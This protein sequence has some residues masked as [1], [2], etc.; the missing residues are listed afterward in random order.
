MKQD[1]GSLSEL[2]GQRWQGQRLSLTIEDK[3]RQMFY[4]IGHKVRQMLVIILR[5]S[6][7][8]SAPIYTVGLCLKRRFFSN[9]SVL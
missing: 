8:L 1:V 2:N 4:T 7:H 6:G 3:V 5:P 9:V